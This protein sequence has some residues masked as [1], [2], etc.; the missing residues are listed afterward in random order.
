MIK[1]IIM[2]G[3]EGT[4]LRPL[5][6][7]RAKPMVPVINKPTIEHSIKL[8]KSHGITDITLSIYTLPDNFQN[9]FGDG[10]E[11]GV[12]IT[13]SVEEKPLGTAGGVR[14]AL[15]RTSDTAIVLSGDGIIDFDITEILKFH[16]EKKSSLTVVLNRAKR[17]TDYGIVIT[18][19]DGRIEKFLEKPSWSEV[20]TDTVNTG[21][22]IIEPADIVPY[23]PDDEKFDFSLDL[24]PRLKSHDIPMYGF[25]SDGYWCDIGNLAMYSNV[26]KDILEGKVN[27]EI[28]GKKIA[29]NI[30]VGRD[31]EIDPEAHIRGPIII[32][33]F[34]RIKKGADI[35]EFTVIGDN[36]LIEENASVKKS[37]IFHNTVVGRKCELRGAIVGK[38]CVLGEGVCIYEDAVVADDCSVG[39]GAVI[40]AGI[41]VWPDK[42]IEQWTRI[43]G[44]LIWGQTEKKS[45]FASEGISGTFNVKIT[46]E[47]ASKL[48]SAIGAYLGKNSKIAV[49]RDMTRAA[50]LIDHAFTSGLL[51]M[52]IDVYQM[53]TGTIPMNRYCT[54][55][56]NADMG[57]YIQVTLRT[58]LQNIQIQF[59]DRNGFQ[60]PVYEEKQIENIFFRG[61]YPRK[62]IFETGELLHPP[63]QLNSYINNAMNYVNREKIKSGNW[64][65]ILDCLNGTASHV[66][67][68]L[69]F[70]M[71]IEPTV[72]RGQLKQTLTEYDLMTGTIKSIYNVVNMSKMNREIGL[73]IGAHGTN[74]TITDETG[75]VL[76]ND[77][78]CS[79]LIMYYLDYTD[80]RQI[81]LP[82]NTSSLLTRLIHE[83]GGTQGWTST[84]LRKPEDSIDIFYG[85]TARY[86]LLELKFDP[87]ITFLRVIEYLTLEKKELCEIKESLPKSNI[88]NTSIQ[89][90]IEQKAAIMGM[91]SA[92]SENSRIELIDGVKIFENNSWILLLPDAS[93]PLIHVFAEGETVRERDRLIQNYSEKIKLFSINQIH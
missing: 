66:I 33:S 29:H 83:K 47:F 37:I 69:L 72:L 4:R 73:I 35:S 89:C 17:P 56:L 12:K 9:Y 27:I 57:V 49:S 61:D 21:M 15:G 81:F 8:L 48:G 71:G 1:A 80:S 78:I 87:M 3:G 22:Y 92:E 54:R 26:H 20:Y 75:E 60:I 18:D 53:E 31:V 79:I 50:A 64:K 45:L 14:K 19:T 52:G 30:W 51:S 36:C 44:D 6:C 40:Q 63:H 38:R 13:Y 67:P 16:R 11:L 10:S 32:G 7:I 43:T 91:L 90:T 41:R 86:P 85:E 62:D 58:G 84:R 34:T 42:V 82:V 2:A 65:L 24:F 5:T 88:V 55:F 70:A 28:P 68:E 39:A 23:I 46:P 93:Q 25:I 76:T 74:I 59:F 77:D